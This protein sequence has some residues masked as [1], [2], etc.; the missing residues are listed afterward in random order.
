MKRLIVILTIGIIGLL[1][2]ACPQGDKTV[3]IGLVIPLTGD[4]Q[5]Y[6]E[7]VQRGVDLAFEEKQRSGTLP[8]EVELSVRDSEYDANKAATLLDELYADGH[9]AAIG[10]ITSSEAIEMVPIADK[11]DRILLSPSATSPELNGISSN[12]FR[13][14]P[15]DNQEG[16]VM[17]SFAAE[18]MKSL[19]K[20]V[21]LAVETPYARG[22][23][24]VFAKNYTDKG[25]EILETIEFPGGTEISGL[26]ERAIFLE[27][28]GIYVAALWRD[29][30][31]IIK[32][33]KRQGYK[34]KILTTS[35]FATPEALDL[36][37]DAVED[38]LFTQIFFDVFT[39]GEPIR[40]FVSAYKNKYGTEPD[41][42][43]AHGYD[44]FN[45]VIEA[46]ENAEANPFDMRRGMANILSFP[47]VTGSLQFNEKGEVSKFPRVY[48]IKDG[49]LLEYDKYIKDRRDEIRKRMREIEEAKRRLGG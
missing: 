14:F 32:E 28:Q 46:V 33:L 35:A 36:P 23:Q 45:V 21:I 13:I 25:G 6:A 47:G 48:I 18:K 37:E 27:P 19:K 1:T 34:G 40:G 49:S 17:A 16:A 30:A 4:A 12:F 20:M 5:S 11:R 9:L 10:G 22:I 24:G 42:Y 7:A 43:A 26:V 15:S 41:L 8:F 3:K 29:T 44:A 38:V 2:L 31:E 39:D